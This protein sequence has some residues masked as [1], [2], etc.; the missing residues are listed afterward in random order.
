MNFS[1]KKASHGI[2]NIDRI[3]KKL[4]TSSIY[5]YLDQKRQYK[6]EKKNTP[7]YSEVSLG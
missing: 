4:N 3:K 6:W 2:E 5:V 1:S 7:T